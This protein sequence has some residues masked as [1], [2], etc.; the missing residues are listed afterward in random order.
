MTEFN[1]LL[2]MFLLCSSGGQQSVFYTGELFNSPS[3]HILLANAR[4]AVVT[5][6]KNRRRGVITVFCNVT[7]SDIVQLSRVELFH[8]HRSRNDSEESTAIHDCRREIRQNDNLVIFGIYQRVLFSALP[9]S[10]LDRFLQLFL[11]V[12]GGT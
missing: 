4:A 2:V 3:S 8:V 7:A 6:Q 5:R 1:T 9:T 10:L 12:I 11:L